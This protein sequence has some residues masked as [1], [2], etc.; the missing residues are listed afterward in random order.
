MQAYASNI[1]FISIKYFM[2]WNKNPLLFSRRAALKFMTGL[3]VGTVLHNLTAPVAKSAPK[4]KMSL[5][6]VTWIGL[7]AFYMGAA[8][9]RR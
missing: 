6:G 5:G 3:A 4:M 9:L 8:L 1:T 2:T 7:T